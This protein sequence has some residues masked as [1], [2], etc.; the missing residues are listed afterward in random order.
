MIV[1]DARSDKSVENVAETLRMQGVV[2]LRGALDSKA[3]VDLGS[4]ARNAFAAMD[5]TRDRLSADDQR[6]LDRMEMPVSNPKDAFRLRL[7]NYHILDSARLRNVLHT[8]FGPFLWL[9]PPMIR[10]QNPNAES[11]FLPYHQDRA[12]TAHYQRFYTCWIPLTACG[13]DAPGLEVLCGRVEDDLSHESIGLWESG[14]PTERLSRILAERSSYTPSLTPG[15]VIVFS[16]HTLH[17]TQ[18]TAKM[19]QVRIS[20]DFRAVPSAGITQEIR[21]RRKFVDPEEFV[22][23]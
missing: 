12:Y 17:R 8:V 10:R 5:A 7:D 15:D 2:V 16:E 13:D 23:V 20:I 18:G 9:Y 4:A 6:I 22:Y 14:I 1:I 21:N 3:V 11:A 19:S